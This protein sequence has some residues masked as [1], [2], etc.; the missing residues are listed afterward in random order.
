M[1]KIM[2]VDDELHVLRIL[3]MSLEKQGYEIDTF[4]NGQEAL[5]ALSSTTPD[6]LITD[7]QMPRM[8]GEELCK[9]IS[10]RYPERAYLIIVLTSRTEIE[11][12]QWS[13]EIDNLQFLEKPVSMRNLINGL[14]DYFSAQAEISKVG[15]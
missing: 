9:Q 4:S 11:H 14:N 7:I 6:V 3:K 10:Q 5:D 2:L 8:S 12:R 15:D 1:K 13:A